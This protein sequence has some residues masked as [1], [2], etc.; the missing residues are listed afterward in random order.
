M[1]GS[2]NALY[3]TNRGMEMTK[4]IGSIG[5]GSMGEPMAHNLLKAG[6]DVC[7]YH[8]TA[9]KLDSLKHARARTAGRPAAA[10]EPGGIVMTMV[11][12]D[13]VLALLA[14]GDDGFAV[15]LGA[16]THVSMS[17]ISPDTSRKLA[18]LH[19]AYGGHYLAAPVF[20]RPEAAAAGKLCICQSGLMQAKQT[21]RPLLEV[22]S[23]SIEDF[24]DETGRS[25]SGQAMWKF[26]YPVGG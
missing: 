9:E 21:A 18:K 26:P 6:F 2:R 14:E 13:Q 7:V 15:K 25:Q 24:G 1:Q 11:S 4:F 22:M 23:Q 19:A 8:R 10:V 17:S 20:G 12:N 5:S 16:G 3:V